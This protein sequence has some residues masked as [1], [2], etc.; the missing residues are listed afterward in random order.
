MEELIINPIK[1]FSYK[2]IENSDDKYECFSVLRLCQF[3]KL[4][5]TSISN[6]E[7]A[8]IPQM[9]YSNDRH[10]KICQPHDY[11]KWNQLFLSSVNSFSMTF[12]S[13]CILFSLVGQEGGFKSWSSCRLVIDW[14]VALFKDF[15][16][17][18]IESIGKDSFMDEW[19]SC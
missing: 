16:I 7:V 8:M 5:N 1:I 18:K 4:S 9:W 19:I 14:L 10:I 17:I 2:L 12:I 11:N 6:L 13:C 3:K 15:F